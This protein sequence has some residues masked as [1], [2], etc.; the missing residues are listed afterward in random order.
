M[1]IL[2]ASPCFRC[3]A[4]RNYDN[5]FKGKK[6]DWCGRELSHKRGFIWPWRKVRR[7]IA[8]L[9]RLANNSAPAA[10]LGRAG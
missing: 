10:P 6:M 1:N 2:S 3:G 7:N 4:L 5:H 8:P 9:I